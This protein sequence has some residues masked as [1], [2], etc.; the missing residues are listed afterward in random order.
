MLLWIGVCVLLLK[1]VVV[2][3]T[4]KMN[5]K[6]HM[7]PYV[8]D[9][10]IPNDFRCQT[11]VVYV[12]SVCSTDHTPVNIGKVVKGSRGLFVSTTELLKCHAYTKCTVAILLPKGIK[13]ELVCTPSRHIEIL[14]K[15]PVASSPKQSSSIVTQPTSLGVNDTNVAELSQALQSSLSLGY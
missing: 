14:A 9:P 11:P 15:I 10:P 2:F 5:S 12:L 8:Q 1:I 7:T 3:L 4:C 6:E 13:L